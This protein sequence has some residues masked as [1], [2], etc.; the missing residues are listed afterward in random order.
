MSSPPSKHPTYSQS[1][2]LE[3]VQSNDLSNISFWVEQILKYKEILQ[4]ERTNRAKEKRKLWLVDCTASATSTM[5]SLTTAETAK[6]KNIH[7]TCLA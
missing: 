5:Q 6:S 2:R 3:Q 4:K 7:L 1:T